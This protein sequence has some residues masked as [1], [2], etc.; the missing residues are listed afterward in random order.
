M[1]SER[2]RFP[3]AL[4]DVVP[5]DLREDLARRDFSVNALAV[6]LDGR[7]PLG[8]IDPFCGLEDIRRKRVRV[9]HDRS[10]I[11]DPTRAFRAVRFAAEL[12]FEL[13]RRTS[14]LL[15]E[16]VGLVEKLSAAR[17]RRE[18]ATTLGCRRPGRAVHQ[19]MRFGLLE[20]VAPG[21]RPPR[22]AAACVARLPR[23]VRWLSESS[24]ADVP[25]VWAVALALLLRS[26]ADETVRQALGRLQP[27]RGSRHV[28]LDALEAGRRIPQALAQPRLRP[29]RIHAVCR[30][31]GTEALL[32]VLAC[33]PPAK[34][35]DAVRRYLAT[36]RE[37]RADIRGADLVRAGLPPG[38]AIAQALDA[39]L[40]AKLD[41]L[42]PRGRDQLRV[43]LASAGRP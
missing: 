23:L 27:D 20:T 29:S 38:P 17:L 37:V 35:R 11:D 4:P 9:L 6:P 1:R 12:G 42:A 43:A 3:A 18:L 33:A 31:H 10:F 26:V 13:E 30:G 7:G 25:V 19:L 16:G 5:G 2:Y 28:V 40:A 39:A 22:T 24:P 8:L 32:A 34:V 41:G 36:L 15:R 14:R 21:L